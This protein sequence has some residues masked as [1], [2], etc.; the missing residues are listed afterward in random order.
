MFLH[1]PYNEPSATTGSAF[2]ALSFG[3]DLIV[4]SETQVLDVG[5]EMSEFMM[6]RYKCVKRLCCSS[7]SSSQTNCTLRKSQE[8]KSAFMRI[9]EPFVYVALEQ[10][11][12]F[13]SVSNIICVQFQ[14]YFARC[15]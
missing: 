5:V 3:T 10:F 2:I 14:Q 4:F 8:T 6:C 1:R 11:G 9:F 12:I 15:E 13:K 7:F